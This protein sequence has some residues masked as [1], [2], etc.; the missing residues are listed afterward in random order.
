MALFLLLDDLEIE[1]FL[2]TAETPSK[3]R[4][5]NKNVKKSVNSPLSAFEKLEAGEKTYDW[6]GEINATEDIGMRNS[7]R[8]VVIV[9]IDIMIILIQFSCYVFCLI[10]RTRRFW[11]IKETRETRYFPIFRLDACNYENS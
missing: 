6:E 5:P 3:L 9:V 7:W 11:R 2:N 8:I 4:K 10:V 1:E